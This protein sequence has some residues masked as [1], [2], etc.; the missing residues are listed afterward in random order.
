MFIHSRDDIATYLANVRPD[1]SEAGFGLDALTVQAIQGAD[2]PAYGADWSAWFD[3]HLDEIV[4]GVA[5]ETRG[6]R[7]GWYR[8]TAHNS[9]TRYGWTEDRDVVSAA[10]E[11][12]NAG[13]APENRYRATAVGPVL[14]ADDL[15]SKTVEAIEAEALFGQ[16]STVADF[17]GNS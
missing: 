10:L 15:R 16:D 14:T 17:G 1:L 4:D 9:E 7:M 2:H 11:A 3:E 5:R 6:G 8:F 12:L 13:R